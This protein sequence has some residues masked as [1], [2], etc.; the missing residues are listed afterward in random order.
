MEPVSSS[1]GS[2]G[3]SEQQHWQQWNQ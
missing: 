2:N 1:I 3:T